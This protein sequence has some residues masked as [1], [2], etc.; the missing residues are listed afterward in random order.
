MHLS[1]LILSHQG[2][3]E[4]G[5]PV[6]PMTLEAVL[7]HAIDHLDSRVATFRDIRD[8][9]DGEAPDWSEYDRLDGQFWYLAAGR[10]RIDTEPD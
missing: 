8:R 4:H 10:E 1:H 7:L 9:Y 6:V 3:L 2:K 5:S